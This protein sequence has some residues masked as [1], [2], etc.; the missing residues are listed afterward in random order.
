MKNKRE[1]ILIS[2]DLIFQLSVGRTDL[3]LGDFHDL[4]NSINKKIINLNDDMKIYP[5]HGNISNIGFEKKN[6]P[7]ILNHT[8]IRNQND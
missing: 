4:M 6:N 5:G 8:D 7:F 1:N 3:P 2:G